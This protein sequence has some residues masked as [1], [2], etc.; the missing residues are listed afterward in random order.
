MARTKQ[1]A[2][3]SIGGKAPSKQVVVQAAAAKP[4]AVT[5][6]LPHANGT[7]GGVKKPH[8]YSLFVCNSKICS[9]THSQVQAWHGGAE[10]DSQVFLPCVCVFFCAQNLLLKNV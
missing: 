7:G 1:T 2:R 3:K 6:S 8:R 4:V 10:G 5:K 9:L